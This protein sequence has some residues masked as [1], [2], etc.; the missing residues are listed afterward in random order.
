MADDSSSYMTALQ[1]GVPI[2]LTVAEYTTD[3]RALVVG[4]TVNPNGVTPRSV[5][6]FGSTFNIYIVFR[7]TARGFD[8]KRI[9]LLYYP[10]YR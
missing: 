9:G 7:N 6:I 10:T 5:T 1:V 3:G 2:P 8:K 4:P